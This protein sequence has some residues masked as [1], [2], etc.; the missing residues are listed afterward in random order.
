MSNDQRTPPEVVVF[1]LG[2]VLVDF[3]Y[4]I[5][6]RKI[7]SR[8]WLSASEVQQFI[9]H[10][11]LLLRY[12]TGQINQQEFFDEVSA[13]TGFSGDIEEFGGFFADIFTPIDRLVEFH[14]RLRAREIPTFILSNTNDLAVGH[15][16]RNFP[17]FAN[18][19]GYVF[20]YEHGAMK[21]QEK[22]YRIVE[23]LAGAVGEK[24][25]FLDDRQENIAAAAARGW[26]VIHHQNTDETI[27]VLSSL[28]SL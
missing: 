1:D 20:S 26:Q 4:G 6:A 13:V 25:I 22:L 27:A 19:N 16:R 17:F 14:A 23:S 18:F 8:G 24:I 7:A 2:K 12:E 3:D 11:P 21:P 10:S 28:F 9:D 5:A 15:I